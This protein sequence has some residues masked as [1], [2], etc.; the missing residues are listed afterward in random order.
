[1]NGRSRI[2]SRLPF[3]MAGQPVCQPAACLVEQ[4]FHRSLGDAQD[5]G[6]LGDG[7]EGDFAPVR[8]ANSHPLEIADGAEE[9]D[10]GPD[11]L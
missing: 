1:M 4:C 2:S 11:A 8:R 5:G 10:L 9:T 3:Q 6:N 7:I